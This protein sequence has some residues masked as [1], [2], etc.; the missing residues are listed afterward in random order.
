MF[1]NWV[2]LLK[3]CLGLA[4][5]TGLWHNLRFVRNNGSHWAKYRWHHLNSILNTKH[6]R[7][8]V[9]FSWTI[10]SHNLHPVSDVFLMLITLL[11]VLHPVFLISAG[12]FLCYSQCC[13][14][15]YY[16]LIHSSWFRDVYSIIVWKV[17]FQIFH[18]VHIRWQY[19]C[20]DL[21]LEI[22]RLK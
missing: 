20:H 17:A 3:S 2:D 9:P 1:Q 16:Y 8:T 4:I 13:Y 18:T 19:S 5:C 14:P 11:C 22:H 15:V 12:N 21:R 7:C 6:H 10:S